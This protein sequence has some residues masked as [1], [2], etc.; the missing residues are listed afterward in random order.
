M[1]ENKNYENTGEVER[2][3]VISTLAEKIFVPDTG[4]KLGIALVGLGNY[5]SS[6]LAP[7]LQETSHCYLA[8]LVTDSEDKLQEW[9]TKYDIP[10][11]NIYSYTNFDQLRDNKEIDIIYVVLPN[12]MHAEYVIRSA[13]AGK[14]VICEKPMAL[15]VEECDQMIKACEDAGKFLSIGYRLHFE[16]HHKDV[17]KMGQAK[18]FGDL[19]YI[20]AGHGSNGTEGW[21]LDKNLAGGGP[22]MDLGIYCIQ[23]A[24]YTSGMEPIAVTAKEGEKNNPD[25]FKDIEESLSWEMEFPGGLMAICETSYSS[26]M[27]IL[28]VDAA[29]GWFELSPAYAYQNISGKTATGFIDLPQVNQQALQM[30]DFAYAILTNG[31]VRVPGEM[32]R[33]D[34]K[35]IQAIYKSM[36]TESRIEI[37]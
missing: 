9:K 37:I 26:K 35:I 2:E 27:D 21:R 29:H 5:S 34:V 22:L 10:D 8:G 18:I 7:A 17:M 16:P 23:A 1:E 31:P 24:R 33:T 32:G 11:S 28:H 36:T 6:Q 14:H 25:L 15:S 13:K 12:A 4:K 3:S 20:H 19:S 30:D